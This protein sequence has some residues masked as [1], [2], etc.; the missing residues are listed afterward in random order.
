MLRA[1]EAMLAVG[2]NRNRQH[3]LD[4]HPLCSQRLKAAGSVKNASSTF[5]AFALSI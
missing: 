1:S 4:L 5:V 2:R 3:K